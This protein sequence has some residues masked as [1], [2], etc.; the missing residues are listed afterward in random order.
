MA[1]TPEDPTENGDTGT[2]VE[3]DPDLSGRALAEREARERIERRRREKA[4]RKAER[5]AARRE[6]R[7]QGGTWI[8]ERRESIAAFR[9]RRRGGP[10]SDKPRLKK[11][12]VAFVVLG[13][14]ALAIVSWFFGLIMAVAQDLP[15]LE[16]RAQY[17]RAQNSVVLASDGTE[18]TTLTS[19]EGRILLESEEISPTVKQAVVAVE[20]ERFY[21]HRGIDYIGVARALQQ[22]ILS[23]SA[24]QGGSTITQQFVKNALEAQGSRTILQKVRE[25]ALAYQIER[26]W[27]KDK[28]LTNYLNNIYFGNGAYGIEA[29]ARTYFG[30]AHEGCGGVKERC[31]SVLTAEEAALLAA[32]ISSPTAYDPVTNPDAAQSQRNVVLEKMREQGLIEVDDETFTEMLEREVPAKSAIE[33]PTVDSKAPYFTDWLRQQIVDRYGAGRAFGGGLEIHSTLDVDLQAAAEQVVSSRTAGLGPTSAVVVLENGTANVLA[34]VGG[35]DFDKAPFNL[36]TNGLR[37]PGSSFKPFTLIT[38]LKE[39]HSPD[40]VYE[41]A[42]QEIPFEAEIVKNGEEKEVTDV[43]R[44]A[45]YDDNYLGSASIATATTYSDNSVYAQLGTDVGINDVVDTAHELGIDSKLGDN[46]AIILGGLENGVTPLEMA[47]AY[48]TVANDGTMVSGTLASR[49]NGKG[50]VAIEKV[51]EDDGDELVE[52]STGADG[53][54]EKVTK[55]VLDP[56]IAE[57]TRDILN[58]VVTSGTGKNAQVGDDFVWGKTGTTDN[59]AD[60]WF[61]GANEEITV[62]VWVGYAD[63]ATPML[64]EYGGLPVD[65]GTIPTLIWADIVTAWNELAA[66]REAEDGDDDEAEVA[67]SD[68]LT[69]DEVPIAPETTTVPD[70]APVPEETVEPAPVPE[71]EAP[72]VTEEPPPAGD[73][74]SDTGGTSVG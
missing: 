17:D 72:P 35:P 33:P 1:T 20:D 24:S 51:T 23:G 2:P 62:A 45:N 26:Q 27:S 41:S 44:V 30:W 63:G 54:N 11:L 16:A 29:A 32:M 25:A 15:D 19:N 40:E 69:T 53:E 46:P 12:R 61:V 57:T 58:T 68:P 49:G 31:A 34:M 5:A 38:A 3:P 8:G 42:P 66:T 14:L 48:N 39:G 6:R 9:E 55:Q 13:L 7:E 10:P 28:I 37:Q 71:E 4:E 60:A 22:D 50:P 18:L 56:S 74:P 36:A 43:F 64:T 59:N 52:D 67:P 65:G 47:Y 21:E 70:A 73:V